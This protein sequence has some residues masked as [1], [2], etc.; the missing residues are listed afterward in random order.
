MATHDTYRQL[1]ETT[2][3]EYTRI[4]YAYGDIRTEAVFDCDHDRYL[5]LTVGWDNGLRVHT[6]LVHIDLIDD[7][8]WIQRD[9]TEV[10]IA[11]ELVQAGIPK[12]HIVLGF[13]P[14]EVRQYTEYA[15]A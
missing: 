11:R 6:C 14:P 3:L 1:I 4:P 2:L 15:I 9:N 13:R 8:V 7:K 10:G 12:D 5:L